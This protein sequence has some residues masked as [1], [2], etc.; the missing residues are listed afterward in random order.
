MKPNKMI[1]LTLALGVGIAFA[2]D[3][4]PAGFQL[5]GNVQMHGTKKMHDEN[6]S[7]GMLSSYYIRANIG[8]KY[9]AEDVGGEFNIRA[10]NEQFGNTLVTDV[11]VAGEKVTKKNYDRILLERAYADLKP[12]KMINIRLGR[13]VTDYSIMDHFGNYLDLDPRDPKYIFLGRPAYHD[14]AELTVKTGIVSSTITIGGKDKNMNTGYV[15]VVESVKLPNPKLVAD[16]GWRANILDSLAFPD[17]E[18][19]MLNRFFLRVVD[20]VMPGL[21]PYTE[22]AMIQ[23]WDKDAGKKDSKTVAM[24][25]IQV[26]TGLKNLQL[27]LEGEWL[28]DYEVV[29]PK[30]KVQ[31][32][33]ID[34]NVALAYKA[35]KRTKIQSYIYSDPETSSAANVVLGGRVT[36]ALD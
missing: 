14:G 23:Y 29:D 12:N 34:W 2:A 13:F 20:T 35:G 3:A 36:V 4:P 5:K 8:A 25:G 16:I 24:L 11:D 31:D 7:Y 21:M 17:A 18:P 26:P 27:N 6:V 33:A 1:C 15:R 9:T 19:E 28:Q 32:R 22:I 30:G 10:F